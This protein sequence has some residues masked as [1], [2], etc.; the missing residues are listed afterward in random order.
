MRAL[1]LVLVVVSALA[2]SAVSEAGPAPAADHLLN[3]RPLDP[4]ARLLLRF[5]YEHSEHFREIVHTLEAS[6]TIVYVEVR[7]DGSQPVS[8]G[9]YF[10]SAN[11]D[12]RW[13]RTRIDAGTSSPAR[14]YQDVVHLTG[15]L[16]HELQ[17]AR[18]AAEAPVLGNLAEFERHFRQIGI[19]HPTLLDTMAAREA[20]RRVEVEL[21]G[22]RHR[23][24]PPAEPRGDA[25]TVA[26]VLGPE[27]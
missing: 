11:N 18:E 3:I 1:P 2:V 13:V 6:R 21:R 9:L 23:R 17:H 19:K 8:G 15:I 14:A 27:T 10:M 22:G 24:T 26:A 5:G 16:A 4:T 12:R 7:L 25:E 20:G